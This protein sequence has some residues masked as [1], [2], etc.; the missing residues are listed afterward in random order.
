MPDRQ[1]FIAG[2]KQNA[3]Y[4]FPYLLSTCF[5]GSPMAGIRPLRQLASV[6]RTNRFSARQQASGRCANKILVN[7]GNLFY[8]NLRCAG[9]IKCGMIRRPYVR[10]GWI[11]SMLFFLWQ[12]NGHLQEEC[13]DHN[14]GVTYVFILS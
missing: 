11:V 8:N 12:L 6:R 9:L 14:K 2:C 1:D 13:Q 5:I 3:G 10:Y 4:G 7:C